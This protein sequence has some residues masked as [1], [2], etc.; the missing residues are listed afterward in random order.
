M[1]AHSQR[2]TSWSA[3][4]TRDG[5]QRSACLRLLHVL[6]LHLHLWLHL[7]PELLVVAALLLHGHGLLLH[8]DLLPHNRLYTHTA[9]LISSR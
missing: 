2:W 1:H 8:H 6:H 5:C 7:G 9:R 3:P 4:W